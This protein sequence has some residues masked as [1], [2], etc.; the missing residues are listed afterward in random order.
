MLNMT[1]LI[2]STDT[3]WKNVILVQCDTIETV[4]S[5]FLI[6]KIFFRFIIP[7]TYVI[8]KIHKSNIYFEIVK[9]AAFLIAVLLKKL[10]CQ[11]LFL[12]K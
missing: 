2:I 11:L 8:M 12:I 5:I 1:I 4:N 9:S 6:Y 3:T 7:K 10:G